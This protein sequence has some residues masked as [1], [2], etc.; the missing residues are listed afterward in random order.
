MRTEQARPVRL[1]DYRPPDWLVDDASISTCRYIRP[2]SRVR[3]TLSLRPNPDDVAGA[4]RARRR[5]ACPRR[6]S[7]STASR[8]RRCRFVASPDRLTSSQPPQRPFELD[9]RNHG[10]PLR[11]HPIDGA[12]PFERHLLHAMRGRGLPPHHLFPRPAGRDG[13]L[14]DA[15]RGRQGAGAGAAGQ[16]QPDRARRPARHGRHFAVWHDPFPKP[17]YLFAMV[18]GA[19]GCVEDSF[20]TLS[21]RKV[22]TEDLCRARQGR[23]LRLCDGFAEALDAL[24]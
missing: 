21:G 12:V 11:Q 14:Y 3:A 24:G 1:Q 23:S 13:G 20:V 10:R 2:R 5:R 8:C 9:D 19:L 17:S 18:G 16:R 6:R 7:R 4:A 22:D 15:D